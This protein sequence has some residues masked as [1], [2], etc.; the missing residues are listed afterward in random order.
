MPSEKLVQF[1]AN[2]LDAYNAPVTQ[3]T[4]IG[5]TGKTGAAN[6]INLAGSDLDI[7][8]MRNAMIL[9]E[10]IGPPISKRRAGK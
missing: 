9:S 5:V 6:S 8:A 10:I 7:Q 4:V 2:S 3:K 1:C